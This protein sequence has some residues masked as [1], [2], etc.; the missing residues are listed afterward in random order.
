MCYQRA[1]EWALPYCHYANH[2]NLLLSDQFLPAKERISAFYCKAAIAA[3]SY[4]GS[5]IWKEL[6]VYT[7]R[8]VI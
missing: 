4:L 6:G 2:E 5:S 1:F 7:V 3:E 8:K